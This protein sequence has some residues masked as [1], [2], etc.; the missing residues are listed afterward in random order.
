[1]QIQAFLEGMGYPAIFLLVMGESMGIPLP[2]ETALLAAAAGAGTGRMFHI[3]W[4]I[5]AAAG[6]AIVGDTI[7][8]WIG[9]RGGRAL[10]L[11]L[12]KRCR[13]KPEHLEKAER[14]FAHHGGKAVFLGRSVSYLRVLQRFSF[15]CSW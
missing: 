13:M 14:F 5:T 7:G 11:R 10:V 6:G 1:M 3:W 4:V 12:M 15:E 9:R 2:G 8:Y